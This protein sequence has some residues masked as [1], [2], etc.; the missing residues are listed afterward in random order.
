MAWLSAIFSLCCG[1]GNL[2]LQLGVPLD[3]TPTE[4]HDISSAG[5]DTYQVLITFVIPKSG[6]VG[7][8]V[9]IK[10]KVVAW[11]EH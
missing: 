8:H 5:L 11:L 10:L 3:W 6:K 2:C 1:E 9:A 4:S 7:I